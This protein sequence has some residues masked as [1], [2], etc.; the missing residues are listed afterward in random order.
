MD[1]INV[2]FGCMTSF[3]RTLNAGL[4]VLSLY[5]VTSE[6]TFLKGMLVEV[7]ST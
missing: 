5:S 7:F 3:A 6:N 2:L 4:L 1:N